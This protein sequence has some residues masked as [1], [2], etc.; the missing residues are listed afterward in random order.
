MTYNVTPPYQALVEEPMTV[1]EIDQHEDS[2]KIWATILKAKK[3]FWEDGYR[4]GYEDGG[5]S[6]D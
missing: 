2:G 5:E 6:E 1:D 4:A 3:E